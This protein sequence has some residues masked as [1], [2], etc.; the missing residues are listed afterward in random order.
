MVLA[1]V[2][3]VVA[4]NGSPLS[5]RMCLTEKMRNISH[6]RTRSENVRQ[7]PNC[8]S[9]VGDFFAVFFNY[10]SKMFYSIF[11]EILLAHH[12]NLTHMCCA[13]HNVWYPLSV[14]Y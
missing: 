11:R 8:R 12:M 7:R 6:Q 13:L 10:V 2:V 5:V 1:V 4:F 9:K 14:T 3:A